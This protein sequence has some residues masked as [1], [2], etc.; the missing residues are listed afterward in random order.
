M[1]YCFQFVDRI[2]GQYAVTVDLGC[3][4]GAWG[5]ILKK[6]TRYLIGVDRNQGYLKAASR[7][8]AYNELVI[9]D[10]RFYPIPVEADLVFMSE[11]VEH[12]TKPDGWNTLYSFRN[13]DVLITTP[14]NFFAIGLG[15]HISLWTAE[16]FKSLGYK[17]YLIAT[18][19]KDLLFGKRIVAYK[20]N[21]L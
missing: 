8:R 11:V 17:V 15:P 19:W 13:H 10:I 9:D 7:T 6:H 1:D 4:P 20:T 14:S 21:M 2:L 16:D 3:G 5:P 18:G 12:L